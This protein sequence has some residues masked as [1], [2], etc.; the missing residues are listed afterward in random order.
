L[1]NK[2]INKQGNIMKR[3]IIV[4]L[5]SALMVGSTSLAL[6]DSNSDPYRPA[7]V[8][9][10]PSS[11]SFKLGMNFD[12]SDPSG[13]ALGLTTRLPYL[14]WFKLG[15][16]A[17]YTLAPGIRGNLLI[18]PIKFPVAPVA[19]LDFGHQF[20]FKVPGVS[21]SPTIDFDYVDL[22]GGLAFGSRDG[23]RF[24]LLAGMSHLSGTAHN[25]QGVISS[26]SSTQGLTIADP[27]FSGWVPDAK[28]GVEFLF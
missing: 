17:T 25:F 8:P 18:D 9:A 20:G 12:L 26:S 15:L 3:I 22:Q 19:N 24:L 21:N 6:A 14:P 27:N 13:I 5:V 10:K 7:V 23:F 28:L 11:D 2:T 1:I 4:G 16:D